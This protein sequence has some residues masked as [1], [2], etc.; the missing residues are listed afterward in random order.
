ML[1]HLLV[2]LLSASPSHPRYWTVEDLIICSCIINTP[3]S[4]ALL[5]ILLR[6]AYMRLCLRVAPLYSLQTS[7]FSCS[8]RGEV[9]LCFVGFTTGIL[10]TIM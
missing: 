6:V 7:R 9:S 2:Q 8:L 5:L 4:I 1:A 10:N 3:L